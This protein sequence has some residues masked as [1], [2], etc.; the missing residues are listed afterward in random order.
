MS[1][2]LIVQESPLIP[3]EVVHNARE[4]AQIL[5]DIVEKTRCYQTIK[6]KK[7]LQ[8]E[9]WETIGAFNRVH[10]ETK[11]MKPITKDGDVLGYEAHVQLIRDGTIVGGAIMPCYFTEHACAGK[12]GD[13]KHKACMSAAQTFATSKAYRMNYS[14]VAILAGY[15]PTPAEEM[16]NEDHQAGM[17]QTTKAIRPKATGPQNTSVSLDMNWLKESLENLQWA[18]VGKWLKDNYGEAFGTSVKAMIESLSPE[19]KQAF[20]AEVQKRLTEQVNDY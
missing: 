14:Y 19:H 6:G 3:A 18:N 12:H 8:V 9:A 5:M 2:D 16:G 15:Q 17:D 13:D 1:T 4:Q 20:V 10:A 7:Y 11:E